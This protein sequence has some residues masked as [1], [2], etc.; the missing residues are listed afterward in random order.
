MLSRA[1][2]QAA[3]GEVDGAHEMLVNEL[4]FDSFYFGLIAFSALIAVLLLTYAFRSVGTRHP[5]RDGMHEGPHSGP[6]DAGSGH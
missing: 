3:D 5:D 6:H 1:V 2:V 4:P